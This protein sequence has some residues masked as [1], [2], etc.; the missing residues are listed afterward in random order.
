[1][2]LVRLTVFLEE[3][4]FIK[5]YQSGFRKLNSTLD[6]LVRFENAIQE[7]YKA[8]NYLVAVFIVLEKAYDMVWRHLL[9][10]ILF[11]LGLEGNL[12]N[13]IKNFLSNFKI[14]VRIGD[15]LSQS[16]ILENGLPQGSVLSCILF[17][18][19][20]NSIFYDIYNITKSLFC[21]DGLFW[22]TGATLEEAMS[23]IQIALDAIG[24]WCSFHGPKI[25]VVKTH[26]NIFTKKT[27][28]M[29]RIP[30]LTLNGAPLKRLQKVKY[31]GVIFD[32]GLTWGPHIENLANQCKQPMQMMRR[33]SK[34]NWGGDRVTLKMMYVALVRSRID[35]ACFLYSNAA[36]N[37]LVKLNRIQYEAIRIITGN[38]RF[39]I[40]ENL[41]AEA[42]IM[43]LS[44][45][46][47]LLAL[48]YFGKVYR[49]PTHPVKILYEEFYHFQFYDIR[50]H[51]LPIIGR[52]RALANNL[53]LPLESI[54]TINPVDLYTP[55]DINVKL[56]L[57]KN[58]KSC[59]SFQFQQAY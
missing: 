55:V 58:K 29:D 45:R 53:N 1:M 12:P 4:N 36:N 37:H 11:K 35:Y 3:S 46:R 9:L 24:E 42:N 2:V 20:I 47:K 32:Q 33:V 50:P 23:R 18:L 16:F 44:L 43:P 5:P 13:F 26:F 8:D 15:I 22:A 51:T 21:D 7:T 39:T 54:E 27:K 17:S 14:K 56:N 49:L 41:E 57:L 59:S 10:N 30:F 52:A 19:I 31:L 6:P 48:N 28:D 38:H 40:L 34:Q 25:S